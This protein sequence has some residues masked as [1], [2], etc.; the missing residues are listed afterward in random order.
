M[1]ELSDRD[2]RVAERFTMA[3]LEDIYYES[4]K[5]YK[6]RRALKRIKK[7]LRQV[8]KTS[9]ISKDLNQMTK[10]V[11]EE[12]KKQDALEEI[13]MQLLANIIEKCFQIKDRPD[14]LMMGSKGC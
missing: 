1:S 4:I 13:D 11:H 8:L 12:L 14:Y 2:M 5:L 6:L 7:V 3:F 10:N 9:V